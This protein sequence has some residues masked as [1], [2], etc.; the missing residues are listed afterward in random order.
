MS[1]NT[2]QRGDLTLGQVSRTVIRSPN[3]LGDAV[4]TMPALQA[5]RNQSTEDRVA[6]VCPPSLAPL[7]RLFSWVHEILPVDPNPVITAD[8]IRSFDAHR[9]LVLP[10]SPRSAAEIYAADI[11]ER[12]GFT[13]GWRK[14]MLTHTFDRPR[15]IGPLHHQSLD[16]LELLRAL[17]WVSEHTCL[18]DPEWMMPARPDCSQPYLLLCPGAEYGEAKRWSPAR[19]ASV[20]DR[21][22]EE[23]G[24]LVILAGA[25]NDKDASAQVARRMQHPY[26]N[27]TGTTSLDVFMSW[28]AHARLV[29]SNDSG[30]MHLAAL[31]KTPAVAVFGSTEPAMTGPISESVNVVRED[32]PCSPCFLRQCPIDFRC[33]NQLSVDTVLA[34]CRAA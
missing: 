21:L 23:K 32:V 16:T 2:A 25:E 22:A 31:F 28:V 18:G 15:Q 14:V 1:L 19:F 10:N 26:L 6:V 34:A 33:M 24:W 4:M 29:L 17:G 27:L 8:T 5:W 12:G 13:G 9:A 30:A 7:W 11:P 3:W 20:A